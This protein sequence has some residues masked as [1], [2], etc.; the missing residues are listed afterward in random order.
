[1]DDS[2]HIKIS[3]DWITK[4]ASPRRVQIRHMDIGWDA[5][6]LGT[7]KRAMIYDHDQKRELATVQIVKYEPIN[8]RQGW[9]TLDRDVPGMQKDDSFYLEATGESL[10]ENC[11]FGT[12]L[13]R[14]ILMHQPTLIRNCSMQDTKQGIV[15]GFGG[16]IEGPPSQR[17][18]VENCVFKNL[19][20]R[21]ISNV[22]PSHDYDQKG[23]PQFICRDSVFDLPE[24]VPAFNIVNSKGVELQNNRY[25]YSGAKPDEGKYII[26]KNSPVRKDSGNRFER[27]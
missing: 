14:C 12:Q 2:I 21:A 16:Q 17:L 9:A 7:G 18:R 23:D 4:V 26:L 20:M 13:Q 22:C 24:K 3:G 25:L 19:S 10:I 11:R 15:L 8:F 5:T 27:K 1:M 6:N